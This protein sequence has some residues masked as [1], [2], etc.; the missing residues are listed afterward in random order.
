MDKITSKK[1]EEIQNKKNSKQ[2]N[3]QQQNQQQQMFHTGF[4]QF[5]S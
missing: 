2:V 1:W 4:N 3:R 5:K